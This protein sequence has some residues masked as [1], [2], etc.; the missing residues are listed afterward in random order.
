MTMDTATLDAYWMP[1]TPNRQFKAAPRLLVK[2]SG[3]YYWDD[4]GRKILDGIAGM[5]CGLKYSATLQNK[6]SLVSIHSY[7]MQIR[8]L[9]IYG[10]TIRPTSLAYV[11]HNITTHVM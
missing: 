10:H 2:A 5:W 11:C 8:M 1:F 4:Q 9:S 3:M 6:E 7:S